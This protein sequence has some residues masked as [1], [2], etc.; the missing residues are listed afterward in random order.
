MTQE[1]ALNK[2][3]WTGITKE[4]A[5]MTPPL[6]PSFGEIT[7]YQRCLES[8][9][10]KKRK[11][12]KALILGATP[13]LRDLTARLGIDTTI[14]DV[15]PN[16]VRGMTELLEYS[17]GQEKVVIANWLNVP[18]K[19]SQFDVIMCDHGMHHIFFEDWDKYFNEIKRLLKPDGYLINAFVTVED[20]EKISNKDII[21]IYRKNK[22]TR[23]DKWYYVYRN[24][25]FH[26]DIEGKKYYKLCND[27]NIGFQNLFEEGL[28]SKEE[29]DFF[30]LNSSVADFK[31][32]MVPKEVV[33]EMTA[34]YF[35]IKSVNV[36]L[37]HPVISCHK[38]YFAKVKN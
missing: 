1:N 29:L 18:L 2:E 19:G 28:I 11:K 36:S 23:E 35:T 34:K 8:I 20:A 24:W 16:M 31:A 37:E 17:D 21:D 6:R 3:V 22:F 26:N 12:I 13:E 7:I 30:D 15:N 27:I 14:V 9:I 33:D 25:L 10:G 4:W 38:I 32:V 5:V